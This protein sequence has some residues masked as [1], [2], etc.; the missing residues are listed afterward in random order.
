MV[1]NGERMESN[2]ADS[3]W[4][5][6]AG[7]LLVTVFPAFVIS[8][9]AVGWV[10]RHAQAFGLLD[11]PNARKVHTVPIPLGGGLG[12]WAGVSGTFLIGTI[13]LFAIHS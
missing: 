3:F 7:M 4:L 6:I 2:P 11:K 13:G 12:I 1:A 5:Q 10:K 9:L 8:V